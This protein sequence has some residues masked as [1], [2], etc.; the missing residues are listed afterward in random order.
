MTEAQFQQQVTELAEWRG[1][2][3]A[4]F[5][6]AR[7]EKGWRT[8]VSGPLGGGHADLLLVRDRVVFAELKRGPREKRQTPLAQ[9]GFLE[10][11]RRA[12][13]EAYLWEPADWPEIER[14]LS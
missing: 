11:V 9:R 10:V 5:R 3:W 2:G 7:T 1:W 6:P 8:P 12:G 13:G 14:V 4:H